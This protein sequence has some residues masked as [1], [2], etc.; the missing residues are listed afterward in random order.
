MG[1]ALT[2][3]FAMHQH[4]VVQIIRDEAKKDKLFST[5]KSSMLKELRREGR[6]ELH[7]TL[8]ENIEISVDYEKVAGCELII[9]AVTED[10]AAK[11]EVINRL[12]LVVDSSCIIASNTSSIS[13]SKL[14]SLAKYHDRVIGMHFFNPPNVM[15][16]V[17]IIKGMLT[18][19]TVI[20]T[21]V[22]LAAQLEKHPVLVEEHPGFIVNNLLMPMINDA[23][24]LLDNGIATKENI[25]S[26]M[27]LGANHPMGPLALADFIGNDVVYAILENL[28][29]E[30]GNPHYKPAYT[31]TKMCAAGYFGRKT[32]RGFYEY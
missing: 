28:Y 30:T 22:E 31:L 8:F 5:Y 7:A 24:R 17:E 18:A 16:L 10:I 29:N 32:R 4:K 27:K 13:I 2:C 25:D 9:E 1:K 23:I 12:N 3:L 26:A 15:Q 21:C 11:E 6:Q 14:S 19:D 20:S